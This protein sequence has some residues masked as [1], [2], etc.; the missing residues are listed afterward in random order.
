MKFRKTLLLPAAAGLAL[1]A[2]AQ[3]GTLAPALAHLAARGT[4]PA[5]AMAAGAARP[6]GAVPTPL[7]PRVDRDGRVQVYIRFR[8]GAGPDTAALAGTGAQRLRRSRALGVVQAW[9]PVGALKR[10][11]ALPAVD[12]VGVPIYGRPKVLTHAGGIARSV[13]TGLSINSEGIL[14]ENIDALQ[15][16]GINGA[17]E[18]IGVIS[19]G[20]DGIS[21]SQSAGYL[22]QGTVGPNGVIYAP[23]GLTGS[24]PEGTAML[25]EVHAAAP[26]ATLGF[27][28]PG[29]TVDFLTCYDDFAQWGATVIVDD[30]GFPGA[31]FFAYTPAQS[32]LNGVTNF[33]SAHPGIN[34]VTAGGNDRQ[35]YFQGGY[36]A[37]TNP[38]V[39]SLSPTY[40]VAPATGGAAKRSY[41]S[42]MDFG[43]AAGGSSDTVEPV[44]ILSG[45][46]GSSGACSMT[47]ILT[48]NDPAGGP[49]D[50]FDLF[51]VKPSD[52][53]V[54]ASSTFNQTTNTSNPPAEVIDY[55][56][57]SG[58]TQN[59]DLAVLCY[60]C[61]YAS[62]ADFRFKLY[63]NLNGAGSFKY[64]TDG[65]VAGH[66]GLAAEFTAAAAR[67]GNTQGTSATVESFS[68]TGPFLYGDWSNGIHTVPKP[69]ITGVDGVTVS[70][71]GGFSSPFYGTSAAA[72]NVAVV[73]TLLRGQFPGA[74]S[75][76]SGWNALITGNASTSILSNYSQRTAGAGLVD[77]QATAAA[78]D[79][80]LTASITS[81][82][83]SPFTVNP[84]TNVTFTGNCSYTGSQTLSYLWNFGGGSGI[85]NSTK[86]NPDPVQYA[87][88]GVYTVKFT[89]SDS[90]QSASATKTVNVDAAA[91]AADQSIT[92]QQNQQVTGQVGGAGIGGEQVSYAVTSQ[93]SHG[94]LS[95]NNTTGTFVYYP[96][97]GYS[98]KDSFQFVIDNGVKTSNTGTVSIDVQA[99]TPPSSGGGG[100]GAF[101]GLAL[102]LLAALAA[103][104]RRRN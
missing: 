28:G 46:T 71:A 37:N 42:A 8:P 29:T 91:T 87:A 10:L 49:Y 47:A 3:A 62:N 63:G 50:D 52:G 16:A 85:P 78:I 20:I 15:K 54:V 70:G 65:S 31:Y 14:T 27:C 9:V 74:A 92:T 68:A 58:S 83:G 100:G 30:L 35:D 2:A 89:C 59:L 73:E 21:A 77:A 82:T 76:A 22:P 101:G 75:T 12:H 17:G 45:C 80:T 33:A 23:S 84:N 104:L 98:G 56:N 72:P 67:A 94:S 79:G 61:P 13:P 36:V 81:P 43:Q 38:N 102:G 96:N 93:P 19:N 18:K 69:E 7:Q 66:A 51:L 40:T 60:S 4:A 88:G 34:L 95:F 1:A 57:N 26:D 99:I 55:T 11:A 53:T 97:T 25:E 39:I 86:L 103:L 24:G 41:K 32:F 6:S 90:V 64:L 44:T 48:W 5:K